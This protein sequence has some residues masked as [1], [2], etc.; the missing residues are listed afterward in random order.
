[1]NVSKL[2]VVGCF[3]SSIAYADTKGYYG[4]VEAYG[5]GKVVIRTKE[6]SVGTWTVDT[7]TKVTGK[8]QVDDWVYADVET[9]GH[10]VKLKSEEHATGHAGVVKSVKGNVLTV[11][12]ANT[13]VTWNMTPETAFRGVERDA[14]KA[15]DNI[16]TKIYKNH[17]LAEIT[18]IKH[19]D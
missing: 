11:E 2:V 5:G 3:L 10:V 15:G 17:N 13:S 19:V 6:K 4:V 9:S 14:I 7:K 16:S 12:S 18:F 1:M 8:V